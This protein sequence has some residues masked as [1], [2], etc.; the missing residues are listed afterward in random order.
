LPAHAGTQ[1]DT[2]D[3]H[4][5]NHQAR[6][7]YRSAALVLPEDRDDEGIV[8]WGEPVVEGRAHTVAAAVEELSD[9]LIGKDPLLIEDHWQVMYRAGFYRGGPITMSAIAGVDQA[10][11]D[12]KGKHHG[13]PI[14]ALLA[15]RCATR[16]RCIRGSAATVR[17]T[18]RTTRAP[19]SNAASRP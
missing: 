1:A 9:Y 6:N 15:A 8:G 10:L 19:W 16:S 17:A 12:I 11:W 5:E 3:A 2:G 14:H 18:S 4:H 7:L 13:V